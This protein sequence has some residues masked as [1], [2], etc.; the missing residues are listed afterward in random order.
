MTKDDLIIALTRSHLPGGAQIL[1]W[2]P[3]GQ[4][5]TTDIQLRE[6]GEGQIVIEEVGA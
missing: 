5:L 6:V 1:V 2:R 3:E 4:R